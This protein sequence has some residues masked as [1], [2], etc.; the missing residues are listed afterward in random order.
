MPQRLE[1][2]EVRISRVDFR[3]L[4][5]TTAPGWVLDICDQA[6][7]YVTKSPD[8]IRGINTS[9]IPFCTNGEGIVKIVGRLNGTGLDVF[10]NPAIARMQP[11]Y[12]RLTKQ[13]VEAILKQRVWY[14]RNIAA[15]Y[16]MQQNLRTHP[17]LPSSSNGP[18]S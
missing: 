9:L 8:D 15:L 2:M 14:D 12:D 4:T 13:E 7:V 16:E 17:S 18:Y 10:D 3:T 1:D 6:F 11:R 5:T